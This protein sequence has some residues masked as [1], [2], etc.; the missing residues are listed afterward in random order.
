MI[1]RDRPGLFLLEYRVTQGLAKNVK[2]CT[3]IRECIVSVSKLHVPNKAGP[4][5]ESRPGRLAQYSSIHAFWKDVAV[6]KKKIVCSIA[7]VSKQQTGTSGRRLSPFS[8][9]P[10]CAR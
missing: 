2:I 5:L 8:S 3:A 6:V 10:R 7:D 4:G 1:S 9:L